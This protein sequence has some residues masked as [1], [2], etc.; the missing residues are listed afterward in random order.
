MVQFSKATILG[1]PNQDDKT[2]RANRV[3]AAAIALRDALAG[4]DRPAWL[5]PITTATQGFAQNSAHPNCI[6][7]LSDTIGKHYG[8]AID[9]KWAFIPPDDGAFDFDGLYDQHESQSRIPELFDRLTELLEKIV[10]CEEL[11]S[12]KAI[13]TLET[14]IAT[15]K[16]NRKGSFFSLVCTWDFTALFIK[17][18]AWELLS[19]IPGLRAVVK[20]VRDTMGEINTAMDKL[21]K[22]VAT[23]LHQKLAVEFPALEYR[24]LP[25]PE[26]LLLTDESDIIDVEVTHSNQGTTHP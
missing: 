17:N 11:D 13:H 8:A 24:S 20:A 16:K 6:S 21:H 9:H 4:A 19:E 18:V 22:D 7:A 15:L 3:L 1:G 23:D 26:P 2:A 12:R 25:L 14:I 5:E 10:Q